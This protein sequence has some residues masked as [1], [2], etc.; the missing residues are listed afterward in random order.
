MKPF[1]PPLCLVLTGCLLLA[2]LLLLTTGRL[3]YCGRTDIVPPHTNAVAATAGPTPTLA[4]PLRVVFV[5]VEAD[6]S[7]IEV[8]WLND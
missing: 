5:H 4:P 3:E 2:G 8:A 6:K 7:D 1:I